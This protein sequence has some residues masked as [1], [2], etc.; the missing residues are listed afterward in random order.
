MKISSL[1]IFVILSYLNQQVI[2]M[3]MHVARMHVTRKVNFGTGVTV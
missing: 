3:H 1:S 2:R